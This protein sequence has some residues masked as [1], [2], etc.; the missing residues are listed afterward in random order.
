M[1]MRAFRQLVCKVKEEI[2]DLE[3][4]LGEENYFSFDIPQLIAEGKAKTLNGTDYVL[5]EFSTERDFRYLE[6]GIRKVQEADIPILAHA[7]RYGCLI[8]KI[9]YLEELIEMGTYIQMNADSIMEPWNRKQK[10]IYK[11]GFDQQIGTLHSDRCP[12]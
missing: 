1:W 11:K 12:R 3:L 6:D 2:P 4:Y 10:S 8:G 5:L 9:E 7:E